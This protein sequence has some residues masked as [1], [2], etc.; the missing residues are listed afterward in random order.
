MTHDDHTPAVEQG[1]DTPEPVFGTVEQALAD[2]AAGKFVVV[3]DDEDRENEGDLVCS[4]ELVT[5]EMVN[6]MLEAKGMIC[7]AMTNEW[8]DRLGLEMQVDHNTEAMSTAFTVSIDAAAKYGVSTGISASDRATTIR[9]AVAPDATRSDLRVPGHIHPLRARNGGVLQRVGHTEAAVDL[10]RLAGQRPAGVICEI[11]NKDGT[12]ARR[13]QLEVFAKQHGL[14]FITIAQLVAYR[15]RHERLVHRA[16][17]AR[18]PTEFGEWRIMGYRNDVDS[19]E[20]LALVFGDVNEGED[21]LVRMHSKCLTGDV[22][23]SRRCDCGWQ[24]ETAM[25]MIRVEGRGVIVYLDQEGR[26]IGLLNKIKAYELQDRGADTVEANERLGFAPDLRNYG[27]GAQ[28][29]LDLGV[30]SIRIMTNN[31]RKLVGLDGYGLVLKDRVRI[32]APST[33]ENASYLE[34]KRTKLGHLFAI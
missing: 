10:A 26:G 33:S 11:L 13:P 20:H 17:D 29:L 1:A 12:T 30:R 22:F 3:A 18:L 8:A 15:L 5:P 28:I 7:L 31:P 4:A 6:F 24:L 27:I 34:T 14:T 16:A 2:I 21:I 25:D 23:H 9:V 32:E 19:R